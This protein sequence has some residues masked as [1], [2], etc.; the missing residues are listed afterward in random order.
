M[1]YYIDTHTHLYDEAFGS[2][3]EEDAAVRRAIDSGVQMMILPDISS[4]ERDRMTA[5]HQRWP[6]N[7]RICAALHPTEIGA[8]WKE[9]IDTFTGFVKQHNNIAAIGETGMD[10]YWS[11]EFEE[12]QQEVFRTH[13]ETALELNLPLIIHARNATDQIFKCLDDYRGRGL[14]GVFHAFSGSIETFRRLDLYGDW[15]VGIGGVVTFKNAGI[16]SVVKDIPL[17]RIV[18]ETDSPYLTP[19]PYRGKRNE[20]SYIPLIASFLANLKE[21]PEI[22]IERATT[23]NARRIFTL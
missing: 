9:E 6:D 8:D 23:E 11:R 3:E 12:V 2:P 14:R 15:M 19:V 21:V 10:L 22:E 16:A 5:L 7:T 18:L 20:S 13:I 1:G 4:K 17:E